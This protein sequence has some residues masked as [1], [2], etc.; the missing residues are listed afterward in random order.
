MSGW[1]GSKAVQWNAGRACSCY[2]GYL[3]WQGLLP[4]V[5]STAHTSVYSPKRPKQQDP[6]W[7]PLQVYIVGDALCHQ[8]MGMGH[9][10]TPPS[11]GPMRLPCSL[12][13]SSNHYVAKRLSCCQECHL[14]WLCYVN[15]RFRP[16]H[17]PPFLVD[18]PI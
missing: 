16:A 2:L 13:G 18:L 9:V 12:M 5:Q 10:T 17:F 8:P 7:C 1:A 15:N 14:I 3:P 4:V 11:P 6:N